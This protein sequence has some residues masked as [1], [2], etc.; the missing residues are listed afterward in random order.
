MGSREDELDRIAR[1][2]EHCPECIKW[3][4]G[5]AVPGEGNPDAR[6]FFVGEAPGKEESS[7]GRP[8]VGRSGKFLRSAL[9]DIGLDEKEIYISSPVKYRPKQATPSRKNVEHGFIHL[10]KQ[11]AAINPEIV[12][13]LG[14]IACLAVLGEKVTVEKAH[15][16]VIRRSGKIYLIT[17]HPAAAMRFPSIRRKFVSDFRKLKRLIGRE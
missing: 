6:I 9:R 7:T 3:G 4:S 15:G 17:F 5:K 11:L 16:S 1:E 12:V 14:R 10:E 8:F 13:L 2:I